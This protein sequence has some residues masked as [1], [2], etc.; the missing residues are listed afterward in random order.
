MASTAVLCAAIAA[1]QSHAARADETWIGLGSG[2]PS[3]SS[4]WSIP[5]NW[6]LAHVPVDGDDAVTIPSL[7]RPNNNFQELSIILDTSYS[8]LPALTVDGYFNPLD[9]FFGSTTS[10]LYF[11]P[12]VNLTCGVEVIGSST[13]A[14]ILSQSTGINGRVNTGS[15]VSFVILG[16]GAGCSG[17]YDVYGGECNPDALWI[18]GAGLG[19]FNQ[20]GGSSDI[21][22]L[23]L[24]GYDIEGFITA[25]GT[26]QA[27]LTGGTMTVGNQIV[28]YRGIGQFTQSGGSLTVTST[29]NIGTTDTGTGSYSLTATGTLVAAAETISGPSALFTQ[30][31][32]TH[33][34]TGV[35][36]L[37]GSGAN[38]GTY[39][40]SAGTL[41][42]ATLQLNPGGTFTQSGGTFTFSTFNLAGGTFILRTIQ[43]NV[44]VVGTLNNTGT[45]N[46]SAGLLDAR[47]INNVGGKVSFT[48]PVTLSNGMQNFG[49]LST[50]PAAATV[51]FNGA[52]FDNEAAMSLAGCTLNGAGPLTNA[53][54]ISG[55][56]TIGGTAGFTNNYFM[57]LSN[58]SLTLSNTGVNTNNGIMDLGLGVQ[59]LLSNGSLTNHGTISLNTIPPAGTS[60]SGTGILT[61]ASGG[62]ISGHGTLSCGL[63]NS[64]GATIALNGPANIIPSFTS[65][66][67]ITLTP[68]ASLTGGTIT[69]TGTL[70]GAGSI[71]NPITNIGNLQS[72]GGALT[73]TGSFQNNSL[74]AIFVLPGSSLTISQ[75]LANNAG[76]I[77]LSAPFDNNNHPLTNAGQISGHGSFSTGGLTNNGSIFFSGGT[78]TINASVLNNGNFTQ[79]GPQSWSANLSFTNTGV[80]SFFTDTAPAGASPLSFFINAGS[81]NF[82]ADQH[83]QALNIQLGAANILSGTTR[84]NTLTLGGSTNHWSGTLDLT[85]NKLIVEATPATKTTSLAALYNQVAYGKSHATGITSSTLPANTALAVIDNAVTHFTTFGGIPIDANSI[86]IAPELLGDANDDGHVDLSDLSTVLNNFGGATSAWTSGNFDGAS[87]INLTDLS[88]VLNNF[89]ASNPNASTKDLALSTKDFAPTPQPPSLALLT[90]G[91][92]ALLT[93]RRRS[94]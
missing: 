9:P 78:T 94:I 39:N 32:G 31:G 26:G 87:A 13:G 63:V 80:A 1:A 86:L 75:G 57:S 41:T 15:A 52:G 69:N 44:Q 8:N 66:G 22:Q 73:L 92:T 11:S 76:T 19:N 18:G 25:G 40:L 93:R 47:L 30:S 53:S 35:L 42:A 48:G 81:V 89:G 67:T 71:A 83:L 88:V 16:R 54:T 91:A 46:A 45:F 64:A 4:F 38:S 85:T 2:Y 43:N 51:T 24:G 20:S 10:L 49:R 17:E 29:F 82:S 70:Q 65:A 33:T 50:I 3:G 72:L 37:G 21:A 60:I 5:G 77:Q 59:L 34:V 23:V 68:A 90:L 12:G 14:S 84:T 27:S 62:F 58:G 79:S 36:F 28:G 61:N 6:N 56:G 7:S 74:G 55:F